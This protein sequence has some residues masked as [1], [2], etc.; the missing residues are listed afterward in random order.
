MWQEVLGGRVT[1]YNHAFSV[2][3]SLLSTDELGNV[4][5]KQLR[6]AALARLNSLDDEEIIEACGCPFD[7]YEMG[8]IS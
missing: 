7:T 3:F 8:E 5:G 6:V 4:T 2:A 1:T